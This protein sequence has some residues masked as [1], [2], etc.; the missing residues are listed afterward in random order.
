M[1]K[2]KTYKAVQVVNYLKSLSYHHEI[3]HLC[4]NRR[5]DEFIIIRPNPEYGG[6]TKDVIILAF[7]GATDFPAEVEFNRFELYIDTVFNN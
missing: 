5:T 3:A 6:L 2:H 1:K 7:E 4:Y